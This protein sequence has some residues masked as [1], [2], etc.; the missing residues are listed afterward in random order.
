MTKVLVL[1]GV[2]E[3]GVAV[4]REAGFTVDVKG[5]PG[6]EELISLIGDYDAMIVRS[7]TKVTADVIAAGSKLKVIGRA[8][9][10][11]DN[12]DVNA[13]TQRGIIV[14][15]APDGNT[16]ATAEH[17]VAMILA[18]ARNIPAAVASLKAGKWDRKSFVGVEVKDKILGIIGL[19]RIGTEVA[20]RMQAMGMTILGY[21]PLLTEE[22]AEKLGIRQATVD[23]IVTEADFITVHTPLNPETKGLLNAERIAKM[24]KGV[25]LINCARG[26]I[27]DESAL[28]KAI[29]SGHVA[30]AALD[31]Y[32][33]EPPQNRE[34]IE[35]P[36]VVCTPHLGASTE[37]AQVNVAVD[38]AVEMVK[39]LRGEPF[40]NAVNIP[41]VRPEVLAVLKPYLPLAEKMGALVGQLTTGGRIARLEIS[42]LGEIASYD[43]APL[44]LS[45]LTGFLRP[46][47][48]DEVNMVN[49]PVLAK[50]RGLKVVENKAAAP[51]AYTSLIRVKVETDR[52]TRTV[53]GAL[54]RR[55]EER[56]VEIDGYY[57]DV[58]PTGFMIV[59]PHVDKPGII[60]KVGTIL[61]NAGIN[62]AFMQVGRKTPGGR[63]IMVLSV[64]N[65]VP[66]G[67]LAEVGK[68]DGIE[69]AKM[70][71]L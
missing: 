49:A 55:N 33:E 22:Q 16:I 10:G 45:L 27:I 54:F 8:G 25:R 62:I 31:V 56:I 48:A 26:G 53:A 69:E 44:T 6:K 11:V 59:A 43:L 32:S 52:G 19:G 1:D 23:E 20:R 18:L 34:L 70:V 39:A 41:S 66:P 35:L 28:V 15:N 37:E 40:K 58:V 51:E 71:S 63:A 9:V 61:G 5:T 42:Y 2:A 47:L 21:D 30:G 50:E 7:Q 24:K 17:T 36:Q 57:F 60:G 46:I 14:L 38:V 67:I 13:A 3:Q 12:I 65:P 68:V 29:K 4:L 64:D